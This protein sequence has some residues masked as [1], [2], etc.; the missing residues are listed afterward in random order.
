MALLKR[1]DR[2]AHRRLSQMKALGGPGHTEH[3]GDDDERVELLESHSIN[4]LY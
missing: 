3:L 4:F 1:G 2:G